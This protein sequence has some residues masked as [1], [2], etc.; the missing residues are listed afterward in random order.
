M[1]P[2]IKIDAELFEGLLA[3][4]QLKVNWSIIFF[5]YRNVFTAYALCILRLFKLKTEAGN[6][7]EKYKI[8]IKNLADPGLA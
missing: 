3:L 6:L 7:T 5:L 2:L 1:A 4:T 8:Q